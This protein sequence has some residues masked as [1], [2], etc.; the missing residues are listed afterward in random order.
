MGRTERWVL[1]LGAIVLV[2]ALS[3]AS[4]AAAPVALD[5]S[6]VSSPV[7][8]SATAFAERAVGSGGHNPALRTEGS[9]R[10]AVELMVLVI[11]CGVVVA[12]YSFARAGHGDKRVLMRTRRR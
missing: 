1:V 10:N 9:L 3:A 4:G 5:A 12:F 11:T 6:R 7:S 2:L 8:G